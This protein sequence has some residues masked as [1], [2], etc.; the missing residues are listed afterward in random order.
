MS[1]SGRIQG[2]FVLA[3]IQNRTA[4]ESTTT[5]ATENTTR[6]YEWAQ[7][8]SHAAIERSRAFED[9][10]T[11]GVGCVDQWVNTTDSLRDK[12]DCSIKRRSQAA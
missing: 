9:T 12:L 8:D 1:S 6:A 4:A 5:A 7:R 2:T 10:L 3:A 11:C